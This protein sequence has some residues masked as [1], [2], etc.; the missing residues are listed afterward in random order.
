MIKILKIGNKIYSNLEKT[1]VIEDNIGN[2][3]RFITQPNPI[4]TDDLETFR[5]QTIDTI[6]WKIGNNIKNATGDLAKLSAANSK[7]I[8]IVLKLLDTLNPDTSKLTDLEKSAYDKMITLANNGYGDSELLNTSL[9][10]VTNGIAKGQ[11][12]INKALQATTIDELIGI[13]NEL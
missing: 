13:L 9:D 12:L 10:A 3:V 11:D 1:I 4:I 5:K 6:N 7:A 8:I 2:E